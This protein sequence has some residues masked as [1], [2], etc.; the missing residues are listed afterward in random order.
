MDEI[1]VTSMPGGSRQDGTERDRSPV[2]VRKGSESEDPVVDNQ[3]ESRVQSI[4]FHRLSDETDSDDTVERE[5]RTNT[6][7]KRNINFSDEETWH[8]NLPKINTARRGGKW[9]KAKAR[10]TSVAK[11]KSLGAHVGI[12]KAKLLLQRIDRGLAEKESNKRATHVQPCE[13]VEQERPE[14]QIMSDGDGVEIVDPEGRLSPSADGD[15]ADVARKAAKRVLQHVKKC[16][17]IKGTIRGQINEACQQIVKAMNTL[18]SREAN[19]ELN[20]LRASNKSLKEQ[21]A[22][23]T[24]EVKALRRAFSERNKKEAPSGDLSLKTPKAGNSMLATVTQAL[25]EFKEELSA[26]LHRSIGNM[27]NARIDDLTSRL[28]PA[29]IAR[30]PLAS[31]RRSADAAN[32]AVSY[33]P[34]DLVTD[35]PDDPWTPLPA[36]EPASRI[37]KPRKVAEEQA[38]STLMPPARAAPAPKSGRKKKKGATKQVP[39]ETSPPAGNTIPTPAPRAKRVPQVATQPP[40]TASNEK[41][42]EVLGRKAKKKAVQSTAAAAAKPAAKPKPKPKPRKLVAPSSA[43]IV[44]SLKPDSEATY[45]SLLSKATTSFSLAEVGIDHVNVRKTAD[46]ARILEVSGTDNGRAADLICE[47]LEGLIGNDARVYRPIKMAGLRISGIIESETTE[48]VT[49]A[50]ATKGGCKIEEVK[51]NLNHCARAQDLLMQVIAEWGVGVA[52]AAEPYFVLP[53]PNWVGASD[54][55]VALVVPAVGNFPPLTAVHKGPG[56][57]AAKWGNGILIGTYFSPNRPLSDFEIYLDDLERLIRR[58]APTP[59]LLMGDLNAKSAAW[60]SAVTDARGQTLRDWVAALGLVVLNRGRANT[61][62]RQQGGSIV[63]VTF[64][65]PVIAHR[66]DNWRVLEDVETLSDHVYIRMTVSPSPAVTT[67]ALLQAAGGLRPYCFPRWSLSSL[68]RDMIEE[69]AIIEAWCAPPPDNIG[70]EQ[71]AARF[72]KSLTTVCDAGMSRSRK[73]P[74]R[75]QVY[76]WSEEIAALRVIANAARRRYVR[77]RRRHHT[78]N[79]EET[80]HE[81]LVAAKTALRVAISKRKDEAREEFLSTLDRDPWGRPYKLVRNKL[82]C[83]PRWT[84]WNRIY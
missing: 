42:T 50:V 39:L 31:D 26:S 71:K 82:K 25:S 35:L 2:N 58:L 14:D 8:V 68:D 3:R 44:L 75:K 18:D 51:T 83:A 66:I 81:A 36:P 41:W 73:L 17:N 21:L 28:P 34:R 16:M 76:W 33:S 54:G 55:T 78:A 7:R 37:T 59:V 63:D 40:P 13:T 47:K 9:G 38:G 19:E 12:A 74:G 57:A 22:H 65:T 52:V 79:E 70:T 77:C 4:R 23:A 67:Q 24:S 48:S 32:A 45:A 61:C 29:P 10:T 1:D 60:G 6:A 49:A 80:L 62:V 20:I 15:V 5:V 56:V 27:V 43:A 72:R 84:L 30:P 46:G 69:A 64:A 11:T 53:Q